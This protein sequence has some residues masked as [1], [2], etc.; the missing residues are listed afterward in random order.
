MDVD[1]LDRETNDKFDAGFS[2][3]EG[4]IFGFRVD[5]FANPVAKWHLP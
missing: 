4:R 5:P 2:P 3:L 1:K